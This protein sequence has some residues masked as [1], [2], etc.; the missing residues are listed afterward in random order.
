[1]DSRNWKKFA[2]LSGIIGCLISV[3]LNAIAMFFYAGGSVINPSNPSFS[4]FENYLSD[5]RYKI[6]YSGSDNTISSMIAL[7]GYILSR[8]L[9]IIAFIASYSFFSKDPN[10]VHKIFAILGISF[11][12]LNALD[13]IIRVISFGVLGLDLV[14]SILMILFLFLSFVFYI[15]AFYLNRELPRKWTYLLLIVT[16]VF[17]VTVIIQLFQTNKVVIVTSANIFSYIYLVYLVLINYFMI[18]QLES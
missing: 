9:F 16:F 1:M 4:F 5:L 3:I 2:F 14:F 10:K 12:I 11:G 13:P 7:T 8:I 17:V 15:V 6:S 18:K